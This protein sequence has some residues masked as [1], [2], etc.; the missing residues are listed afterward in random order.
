MN[1][2]VAQSRMR[3]AN[4][5]KADADKI[6]NI[7]AAEAEAESKYLSGL[8]VARQRKAIVDGLKDVVADFSQNVSGATA[9]DVLDLLL[10]TQYFDV[11]KDIARKPQPSAPTSI[12]LPHGPAS[13][14]LLKQ[15][16]RNQVGQAQAQGKR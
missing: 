9:Q 8:G 12:F 14:K 5:F 10:I 1:D 6:L 2:V 15:D 16:L 7:K 11:M 3:E 4:V 13:I